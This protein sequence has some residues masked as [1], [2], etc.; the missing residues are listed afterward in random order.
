MDK[1]KGNIGWQKPSTKEAERLVEQTCDSYCRFRYGVSQE[2]LD[3]ICREC[4]V[5]KLAE[6]LGV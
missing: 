5:A 6:M 3:R 4:P 1:Y 2:E